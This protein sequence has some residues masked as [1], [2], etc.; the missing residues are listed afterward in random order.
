LAYGVTLWTNSDFRGSAALASNRR[1]TSGGVANS[2]STPPPLADLRKVPD[3]Q[4]RA[5]AGKQTVQRAAKSQEQSRAGSRPDCWKGFD[6]THEASLG[7]SASQVPALGRPRRGARAPS[8]ASR[9]PPVVFAT[10]EVWRVPRDRPKLGPRAGSRI[11]GAKAEWLPSDQWRGR[12]R[13]G[14]PTLL[15]KIDAGQDARAIPQYRSSPRKRGPR[16]FSVFQRLA[17]SG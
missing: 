7:V 10:G 6:L 15:R 1:P 16:F 12:A 3:R 9:F 17:R 11:R 14:R 8:T 4:R 13:R 2:T 5:S